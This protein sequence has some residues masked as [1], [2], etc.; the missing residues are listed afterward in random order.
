MADITAGVDESVAEA[1]LEIWRMREFLLRHRL[2]DVYDTEMRVQ[3]L[4]ARVRARA[5]AV[6][7]ERA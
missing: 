4:T 3:A 1:V 7:G 6:A 2:L 5:R